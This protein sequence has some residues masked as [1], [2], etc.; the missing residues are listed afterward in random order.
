MPRDTGTYAIHIM[1]DRNSAKSGDCFV[2]LETESDA[3]AFMAR[4]RCNGNKRKIADR[5]VDVQFSSQTELMQAMFPKAKC[6]TWKGQ[7]PVIGRPEYEY[8]AGFQGFLSSEEM[9]MTVKFASEPRKVCH[10]A[11]LSTS[12]KNN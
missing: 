6:V 10:C 7:V 1:F 3:L 4:V 2:E 5:L 12:S 8:S 11:S 9:T